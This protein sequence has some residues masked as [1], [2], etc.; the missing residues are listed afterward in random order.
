MTHKLPALRVL[1]AFSFV[2]ALVLGGNLVASNNKVSA[3]SCTPPATTYGTAT[4]TVTIPSTDTYNIWVRMLSPS[5]SANSILLN[6]DNSSCYNV[7]GNASIPA[8]AWT[9]VNYS[10]GN[11]AT[12]MR[13]GLSQGTHTFTLTGTQAG[14]GIDRIE[15]LSD[16]NCTPTGVGDNCAP[17]NVSPPTISFASPA[18]GSNVSGSSVNVSANASSASGVAQVGIKNVVFKLDSNT[19]LASVS[20]PVGSNGIVSPSGTAIPTNSSQIVD[21]NLSIWTIGS[22]AKVYKDGALAGYSTNVVKLLYFNG[23]IYQQTQSAGWW[24]W[25][26]SVGYTQV[27]A[28]TGVPTIALQDGGAYATTWN[29]T[30]VANGAHT[31]TAIATDTQGQ[32]TSVT[33]SINVSNNVACTANP[34]A[35]TGVTGTSPDPTSLNISWSAS[36]PGAG[37]NISQYSVYQG[38]ILL[39]TSTTTSFNTSNLIPNTQYSIT[40]KATDDSGHTSSS[41][42]AANLSTLADF[43][44]PTA[45]ASMTATSPDSSSVSLS[46]GA[47]TDSVGVT[48]YKIYRANGTGTP[49]QLIGTTTG[50]SIRNYTDNT[51]NPATQYTYGVVAVDAASNQSQKTVSNSVT[52]QQAPAAPKPAAATNLRTT[53]VT[54]STATLAW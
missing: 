17:P 39:G 48:G 35:P 21:S 14:V 41:S 24:L 2:L 16:N 26:G 36:T 46:W 40:V 30:G 38:A 19:T 54:S 32:T 37:C 42:S 5:S 3:D 44:A 31:L 10:G 53:L 34:S 1:V 18:V 22:D 51:V 12:T 52:T 9:W 8:N 45:P 25:N 7:G 11:T 13:L 15:A 4:M 50:S 6:I 29:S 33:E 47:S 27:A 43:I 28:P 49:S 20:P 23:S